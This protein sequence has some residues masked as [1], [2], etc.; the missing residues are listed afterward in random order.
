MT[1]PTA[2]TNIRSSF[3]DIY[4]DTEEPTV[5]APPALKKKRARPQKMM[6]YKYIQ[7]WKFFAN[8]V[9][10]RSVEEMRELLV[11]GV[12]LPNLRM[13]KIE[14]EHPVPSFDSFMARLEER[15]LNSWDVPESPEQY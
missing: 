15:R 6:S 9:A 4:L 1:S 11:T 5:E 8:L 12:E 2:I 7:T 3:I 13:V 14:G 10:T